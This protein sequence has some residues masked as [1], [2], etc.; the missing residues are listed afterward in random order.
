[1]GGGGEISKLMILLS[2]AVSKYTLLDLIT[3]IPIIPTVI[4]EPLEAT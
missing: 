2:K 3:P 1:M 4:V